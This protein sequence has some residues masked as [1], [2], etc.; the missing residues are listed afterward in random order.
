M[1]KFEVNLSIHI[2]DAVQS[3]YTRF[4]HVDTIP[5]ILSKPYIQKRNFGKKNYNSKK[6]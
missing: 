3:L 4:Y 5:F 1:K 6:I 2:R